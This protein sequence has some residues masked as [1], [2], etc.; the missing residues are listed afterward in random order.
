MSQLTAPYRFVPL[1]ALVMLPDWADLV[2]HDM[3]FADGVSGE[4]SY[5]ITAHTRL[6]VGGEQKPASQEAPGEVY[7]YRTP[8]GEPAI[9]GS[10]LKGMLRNVLEIASFARF[11]QVEDQ[12]LGVR[13]ISD[14]KNFYCGAMVR[15]PSSAGWLTYE[16][17]RWSIRPCRFARLHQKA[18]VEWLG[19]DKKARWKAAKS[20]A[21]RYALIGLLPRLRFATEPSTKGQSQLLARPEREAPN[22]GSVVVTGQPGPAYDAGKTAKKYEFVFY[23]EQ[24]A[25]LAV[26]PQVMAGFSQIHETSDEW[27]FWLRQLKGGRLERG[28]P[29][30]YHANGDTVESLGLAFMYKLPYAHSLHQAITHTHSEHLKQQHPD[31]PDLLF[32]TLGA[33][34][35]APLRGRINIGMAFAEDRGL[36]CDLGAPVILN[37]PKPTFYPAYIRQRSAQQYKTLMDADA[38]L[39]GWKRYPARPLEHA[40]LS[41]KAGNKVR[42]RLES[43]DE[44]SRFQGRI[45]FHNLRQV[46]LGALLWALDFGGRAELRHGLGMGKPLG[47]GQVSIEIDSARLRPNTGEVLE[48]DWPV[49]L[50]ACRQSF[51]ALMNSVVSAAGVATGWEASGPLQAL[52]EY[53]KPSASTHAYTYLH[54]PKEFSAYKHS[55]HIDEAVD[56]FHSAQPITP[57]RSFD[58]S[59]PVRFEDRFDQQL[60]SAAANVEKLRRKQEAEALKADASAERALLIDIGEQ[61]SLCLQGASKTALDK[62]NDGLRR[63]WDTLMDMDATERE[64]L[65]RLVEQASAIDNKKIMKICKKLR[66]SLG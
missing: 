65:A 10:S 26:P 20:A 66:E 30:F 60:E 56:V 31:L 49:Y 1:S 2:S 12:H 36:C 41:D 54:E 22:E 37:G 19:E 57:P 18:L 47:Y 8:D 33:D 13:D 34:E 61:L 4:L 64:E 55:R 51:A 14:S 48:H 42:V 6:C 9:P 45:R 25:Q 58:T 44:G 52:L 3:P 63:A 15:R 32:G 38:E 43:V 21:E 5:R 40:V 35:S 7:F 23:D 39:A 29:V 27:A 11:R 59:E 46:E 62:L 17:G 28:I 24:S 50:Q 16:S 53:A